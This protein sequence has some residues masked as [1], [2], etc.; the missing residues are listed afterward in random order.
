MV[1]LALVKS[2]LQKEGPTAVP[3]TPPKLPSLAQLCIESASAVIDLILELEHHGQ[4]AFFSH[5]DLHSCS[6]AVTL[7][8]LAKTLHPDSAPLGKIDS[9]LEI[10]NSISERSQ[11][12]KRGTR[13]I[14]QL[15]EVLHLSQSNAPILSQDNS[16][17]TLDLT[18]PECQATVSL[19]NGAEPR[20]QNAL[21]P[22]LSAQQGN[23]VS[24]DEYQCPGYNNNVSAFGLGA[25][26]ESWLNDFSAPDIYFFGFD[27][28][29]SL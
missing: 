20:G 14:R 12:A 9:A 26:F 10:L 24:G 16:N 22:S 6:S 11:C 8:I 25:E 17:P 2:R 3:A 19:F 28:F 18:A 13:L 1:L 27:G 7:L 29:D 5:M 23:G 4:I 15:Y 21:I